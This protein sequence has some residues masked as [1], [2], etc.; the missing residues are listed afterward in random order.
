MVGDFDLTFFDFVVGLGRF[1]DALTLEVLD[2]L[3]LDFVG[4][5]TPF[6]GLSDDFA[7]VLDLAFLVAAAFVAAGVMTGNANEQWIGLGQSHFFAKKC[8][9]PHNPN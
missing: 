3:C 7:D 1:L 6:K 9:E 8:R 2:L 4:P 5:S